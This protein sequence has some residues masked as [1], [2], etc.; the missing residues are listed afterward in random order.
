MGGGGETEDGT[1]YIDIYIYIYY[2][3][4]YIYSFHHISHVIPHVYP[5]WTRLSPGIIPGWRSCPMTSPSFGGPAAWRRS[6]GRSRCLLV[7][8]PIDI[9][10][11]YIYTYMYLSIHIIYSYIYI[12]A[13]YIYTPSMQSCRVIDKLRT[14][15]SPLEGHYLGSSFPLRLTS[16]WRITRITTY[17]VQ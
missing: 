13:I 3:Y 1:I 7:Y 17:D 6:P 15:S 10:Y 16:D 9:S 14:N 8:K 2:N 12:I 11:I 4:N 5:P